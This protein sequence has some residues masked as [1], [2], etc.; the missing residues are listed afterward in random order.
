MKNK[1]KLPAEKTRIKRE[2]I[3]IFI[4]IFLVIVSTF[5]ETRM[6]SFADVSITSK[7]IVYAYINVTIIL[8]FLMLFLIIRNIIKLFLDKRKNALG[9]KLRSKL[10]A[11]FVLVSLIP[12]FFMFAVIIAAGFFANGINKWY[13]P[14]IEKTM[15]YSLKIAK[16]L[17]SHKPTNNIYKYARRN[18]VHSANSIST[19]KIDRINRMAD[20]IKHFYA[21][22]WQVGFLKNP[23]ETTYFILFSTFTLLILF[24]SIWVGFYLSKKITEPIINLVKGTEK[25]A[26]GE[27]DV[28]INSGSD[29][30][31]GMLIN[32]FNNMAKDL[33][34]N[35]EIIENANLNLKNINTEIERRRKYI[36]IIL[37]NIGTGVITIDSSGKIKTINNAAEY[38][39][40]VNFQEAA[41]KN[42]KDV[43]SKITFSEI[44]EII[45]NLAKN[46]KEES[47]TKEMKLNINGKLHVYIINVTVMKDE[48][49]SYIGF[50][51]VINDTTD[52]MK[53]QRIAAWEEVAK[54]IAH[55]I[56]NPLTP[57]KLSAQRLK[58]KFGDK[59]EY[60]N[61]IFNDS[62][63][64][65]IKEVDDLKG[66]VD[67]FSLYARLP[68]ANFNYADVNLLIEESFSFYSNAHKNIQFIHNNNINRDI[69]S[70][71]IDKLQFKRAIIN[72]LDNAVYSINTNRRHIREKGTNFIK[73]ETFFNQESQI[74]M[75]KISDTGSGIEEENL[76][77]IF[78][79]YFSTK[80]G[81]TGLGL[82]ITR[83]II[84][85]NHGIIY[86]HNISD[87]GAE[88]VIE[89]KLVNDI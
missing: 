15:G 45:K 11:L 85:E 87:G 1:N 86:A 79:P 82:A 29:D 66:L 9:S 69:P 20:Y 72:I 61:K 64:I 59:L 44:R 25:I 42:Y 27:L 56:K 5:V 62:I 24:I 67:E 23:I 6:L 73:A 54:R 31:I 77:N 33:K 76:P 47:I 17:D 46:N 57:I 13:V 41:N 48:K 30:E 36:E 60:D 51:I 43:F 8:F 14:G 50:I 10:V 65:I 53:A 37:K 38:M 68:K 40:Q 58:R 70:V 74:V 39:F 84:T 19:D 49:D 32:S 75:M 2:I 26:S 52:M 16:F 7:I 88:F 63:D 4:G 83:N 21:E 34:K 71:Y 80:R 78:E 3:F 55:E 28:N 35:K 12:S 81:G 18:S 22:Y 89:I